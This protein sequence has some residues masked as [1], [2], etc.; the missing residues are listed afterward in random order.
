MTGLKLEG[1]SSLRRLALLGSASA[2]RK[3]GFVPKVTD[4]LR[5]GL[6]KRIIGIEGHIPNG[7]ALMFCR[8]HAPI[9]K[10][11][12]GCAIFDTGR[13]RLSDICPP[14]AGETIRSIG[15]LS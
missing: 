15:D 4:N 13:K 3:C 11:S 8:R 9:T 12:R 14:Y 7:V 5:A 10:P 6:L 1:V 2:R